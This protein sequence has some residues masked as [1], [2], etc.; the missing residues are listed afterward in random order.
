MKKRTSTYNLTQLPLM[1]SLAELAI[2]SSEAELARRQAQHAY[3]E[4]IC[5]YER[6]YGDLDGRLDPRNP[7]HAEALAYTSEAYH[8]FERAK[9]NVYN[10][11]R[12]ME[13][14]VRR[15][16]AATTRQG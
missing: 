15:V 7:D 11:K 5:E 2:L 6:S 9:R 1:L 12:R 4:K 10:I 14:A 3:R 8:G 13:T 16:R